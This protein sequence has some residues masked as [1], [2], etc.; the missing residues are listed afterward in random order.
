MGVKVKPDIGW[1]GTWTDAGPFVDLEC[2]TWIGAPDHALNGR[3]GLYDPT[4]YDLSRP[5]LERLRETISARGIPAPLVVRQNGQIESHGKR[6]RRGEDEHPVLQYL[7][8]TYPPGCV[9]R[10]KNV[11]YDGSPQPRLEVLSGNS[12]WAVALEV[13]R[14]RAAAGLQPYRAPIVLLQNCDDGMAREVFLRANSDQQA[15]G[16]RQNLQLYRSYRHEGMTDQDEL[17]RRL[18]VPPREV[19]VYG[20]FDTCE[21]CVVEAYASGRIRE[22]RALEV[23]KLPRHEQARAL[24]Q[25]PTA[26][27]RAT[28]QVSHYRIGRAAELLDRAA[29]QGELHMFSDKE[30]AAIL[31]R[32]AGQRDALDPYPKVKE[33]VEVLFG[34]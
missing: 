20:I 8:R 21:D 2:L 33:A 17:A 11:A 23:S 3:Y 29:D 1:S 32:I 13:N 30:L 9:L 18:G 15:N 34:K 7:R 12:R 19:A 31:R 26:T 6:P 27:K 4:R 28:G 24:E 16:F 10:G 14:V 5:V 25:K 22:R